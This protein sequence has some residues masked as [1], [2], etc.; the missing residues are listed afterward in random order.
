MEKLEL[1]NFNVHE[2]NVE[3]INKFNGGSE[4]SEAIVRGA[5][6]VANKAYHWFL[7]MHWEDWSIDLI[8]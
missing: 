3:E 1:S 7:E 5:G 4:L 8:S 6:Y 2:M